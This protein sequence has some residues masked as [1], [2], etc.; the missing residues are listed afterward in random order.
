MRN[1]QK[2]FGAFSEEL[3]L[4][5]GKLKTGSDRCQSAKDSYIE[6]LHSLT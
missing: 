5:F 3:P 6:G 1:V 4:L 2:S